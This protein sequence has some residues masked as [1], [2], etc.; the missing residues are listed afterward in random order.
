MNG[1]LKLRLTN[2]EDATAE[3]KGFLSFLTYELAKETCLG[4]HKPSQVSV[5]IKY[6]AFDLPDDDSAYMVGDGE[7]FEVVI[8]DR[9]PIGMMIDFLIH[10]LAHVHSWERADEHE[11]HCD[12]FGKSYALLYRKYLELYDEY[13]SVR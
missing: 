3:D 8:D 5:D 4:V 12:E 9:M 13:W 10:E 2:W 11:D 6:K 1:D 7:D